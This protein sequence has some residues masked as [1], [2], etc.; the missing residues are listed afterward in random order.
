MELGAGPPYFDSS[1]PLGSILADEEPEDFA[2]GMF[3]SGV[4]VGIATGFCV[5]GVIV[6]A[7]G[8]AAL[9]GVK[10]TGKKILKWLS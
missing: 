3:I 4:F 8:Y 7:T 2:A 10:W 6:G 5:P 1:E 9:V